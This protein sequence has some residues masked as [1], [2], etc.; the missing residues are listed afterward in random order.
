MS[1]IE[2]CWGDSTEYDYHAIVNGLNQYLKIKT[3]PP[4]FLP[5]AIEGLMALSANGLRYPIPNHGL[6]MSP[7]S[8]M[9]KSYG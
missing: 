1:T 4:S 9:I 6:D 5:K 7:M 2:N 8:S 3:L